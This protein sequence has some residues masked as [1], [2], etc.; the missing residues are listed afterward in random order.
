VSEA[1]DRDQ[2]LLRALASPT[3]DE[4]SLQ[5]AR[6]LLALR[7]PSKV[8]EGLYPEL[9]AH[10]IL[11]NVVAH[12]ERAGGDV[13]ALSV[14]QDTFRTTWP[15]AAL[16][17][18]H[19][20]GL[21]GEVT[22][23]TL[24]DLLEG[25]RRAL[26]EEMAFLVDAMPEGSFMAL[27]GRAFRA[28]YPD[29]GLRMEYDADLFLWDVDAGIRMLDALR[30][31]RSCAMHS[32]RLFRREGRWHAE[33][34]TARQSP[35]GRELHVDIV[36]GAKMGRG[37]AIGPEPR[38]G[39]ARSTGWL[40]RTLLIPAP[41]DMLLWSAVQQRRRATLSLRDLNDAR[42]VLEAD[43]A[44]IDWDRLCGAAVRFGV[45][46][47]IERLIAE[48]ERATSRGLAPEEVHARLVPAAASGGPRLDVGIRTAASETGAGRVVIPEFILA[49]R[50]R[51]RGARAILSQARRVA[52]AGPRAARRATRAKMAVRMLVLR[53]RLARSRSVAAA[54]A[55]RVLRHV[56]RGSGSLCELR[57]SPKPPGD[58]F[59]LSRTAAGGRALPRGLDTHG[60]AVL[61]AIVDALPDRAA[62]ENVRI[63]PSEEREA[64][65]AHRCPVFTYL[66]D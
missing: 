38:R 16:F 37:R 12:L 48:A 41:E 52:R 22:L 17:P 43:A 14:S 66:V 65:T 5:A 46:Q 15:L 59:C 56:G 30:S 57:A 4:G 58:D 36:V 42:I 3:E 27:T 21:A 44:G 61:A 49:G 23:G 24:R 60:R 19:H 51:R 32:A 64:W 8:L 55:L 62:E 11:T 35:D 7:Q 50:R 31:E 39:R 1:I 13:E 47:G 63:R 20:P 6:E 2:R 10:R 40:G 33:L 18:P 26:D 28:G 29:Y 54:W 34:H 9:V 45:A 25:H 53:A